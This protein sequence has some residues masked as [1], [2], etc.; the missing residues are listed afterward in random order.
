MNN[1]NR[2]RSRL[3][4]L[5]AV[6]GSIIAL[7]TVLTNGSFYKVGTAALVCALV[8]YGVLHVVYCRCPHCGRRLP[9]S[10][11][12]SHVCEYCG[13]PLLSSHERGTYSGLYH[14]E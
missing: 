3:R 12:E 2:I 5:M 4:F 6:I 1:P 10:G 11:D 13:S 14:H 9:I 7:L 8:L